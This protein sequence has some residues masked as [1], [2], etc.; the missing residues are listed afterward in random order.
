V[1][2]ARCPECLGELQVRTCHECRLT[3]CARCQQPFEWMTD[4]ASDDDG[5]CVGCMADII[6]DEGT[7]A[8]T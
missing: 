7:N 2:P 8:I 1:S 3:L 4:E 6:N 5:I